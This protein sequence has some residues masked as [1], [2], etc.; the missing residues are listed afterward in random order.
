MFKWW[1]NLDP[2]LTPRNQMKRKRKTWRLST[3]QKNQLRLQSG[4]KSPKALEAQEAQVA[5]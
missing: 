4:W 3:F 2:P 1:N 5:K